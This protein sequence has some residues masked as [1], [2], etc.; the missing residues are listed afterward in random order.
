MRQL[1]IGD[2]HGGHRALLQVLERCNYDPYEDQI[3]FLGDFVDG[4]SESYEVIKTLIE[5]DA[6]SRHGNI[7]IIGNHDKWFMQWYTTGYHDWTFGSQYT[8]ISYAKNEGIDIDIKPYHVKSQNGNYILAND[9]D[10]PTTVVPKSHRNFFDSLSLFYYDK[11]AKRLFVHGG[12]EPMLP[13][14]DQVTDDTYYWDRTLF[15][16]MSHRYKQNDDTPIE[17]H[18]EI[19]ECYIGH[20]WT[21]RA[22]SKV[23][24]IQSGV[25]AMDTGAAYKG[26]LT[27]M[28]V[29]TKEYWQSDNLD[30]LYPN[31]SGR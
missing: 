13:V 12:I 10:I 11:D 1:V 24:V 25:I 18:D 17:F 3:I 26:K 5:L 29:N 27:I 9:I 19:K 28:D 22:N 7:H 16:E 15:K 23:P 14:D 4:W 21:E 6:V 30:K 20:T 31:E 2:I 8:A